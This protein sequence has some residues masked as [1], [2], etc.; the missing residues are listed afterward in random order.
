[1]PWRRFARYLAPPEERDQ[2]FRH[3]IRRLSESGLFMLGV[4]EIA[5]PILT[6]LV[7][8]LIH[9]EQAVRAGH[10]RQSLALA[11][12]G[13]VTLLVARTQWSRGDRARAVALA[14]ALAGATV[15]IWAPLLVAQP[16]YESSAY[17]P[18]GVTVIVLTM[19]AAAPLRPMQVLALGLSIEG[20]Y[21]ASELAVVTGAFAQAEIGASHHVFILVLTLMSTGVC[22]V[23]YDRRRS[24]SESHQQ[25]LRVTEALSSAQ[26][27]AQLAENAA[28]IGK[29]AAALTHEINSPLGALRSSIDTLLALAARQAAT[30]PENQAPLVEMQA[31][32]SRSVQCSAERIQNVVARLQRFISLE[33]AEVK[34]ANLN[35]LL[36]DVALI[37]AGRIGERNVRLEFDLRP[38][39]T[40]TC[41]P[42]LLTAVF[43]SLLSNAIDAVNGEGRIV[44]SSRLCDSTVQVRIQ[45]NGRGMSA[46]EVEHIFDPGFRVFER[47]VS[48]GNWSLFNIRQ[49]IFEHGG[50]IQIESAEGQGASVLVTIPA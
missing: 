9:P 2:A 34:T 22:A 42:Q 36:R 18:T 8:F 10:L 45:D 37:L 32:L 29:L 25:A 13:V 50:D 3:E 20:V 30:A 31:E 5:V 12:V 40:V 27:R 17:I 24:D 49:V 14:S 48:S 38:L 4:V 39:P 6:F 15:L 19:V 46:E 47:R 7:H 28:S 23:L 44:V 33:E 43:S 35:E 1:M 21:A 16:F 26:L 41:R 11:A